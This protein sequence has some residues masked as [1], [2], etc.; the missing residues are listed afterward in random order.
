MFWLWTKRI[1]NGPRGNRSPQASKAILPLST[2]RTKW[3]SPLF[4]FLWILLSFFILQK[5]NATF[6]TILNVPKTSLESNLVVI[7][8][9]SQFR[10]TL[11]TLCNRIYARLDVRIGLRYVS[12]R[13][14]MSVIRLI[15]SSWMMGRYS[16][17][18]YLSNPHSG[19]IQGA[20]K[21]EE[22]SMSIRG[23]L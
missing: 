7:Q 20:N 21:C 14:E 1:S 13:S 15:I 23:L 12:R 10:H 4:F 11:S 18:F 5:E 8:V 2:H 6:C 9:K 3:L 22:S 19:R 16:G 17:I